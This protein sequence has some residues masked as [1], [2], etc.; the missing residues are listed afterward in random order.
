MVYSE[1]LS[2]K[3]T[4]D[5]RELQY[6][7]SLPCFGSF[8]FAPPIFVFWVQLAVVGVQWFMIARIMGVLETLT[9]NFLPPFKVHFCRIY[10]Q[11]FFRA[12]YMEWCR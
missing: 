2:E 5:D 4:N 7:L 12:D 3:L 6:E 1:L 11:P 8:G 9:T 10:S